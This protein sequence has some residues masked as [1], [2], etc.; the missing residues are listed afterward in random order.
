MP[1]SSP[2]LVGKSGSN[3]RVTGIRRENEQTAI[4]TTVGVFSARQ[5]INCAGLHSDAISRL[6]GAKL[7][8]QIVPF[9]GEYYE[10]APAKRHLVRGLI[11]PV[12]DPRFPF[13]GVHFTRRVNGAVEAGPNAVLALKREGYSKLSFS[14]EDA[15]GTSTFPGFWRMAARNW[16]HAV[17]EYYR[18]FS[19]TAFLHA[20]QKLLPDLTDADLHPGGCGVR[21]QAVAVDGKLVD[22][23]LFVHT[24]GIIHVCNVPS[25]AATASLVIGREI[26]NLLD[27]RS[28]RALAGQS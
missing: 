11:Y 8:F 25:P 5:V 14:I 12:P 15:F 4:E 7:D 24:E 23:F 10:L 27:Q 9:R 20:L 13:L 2:L 28:G 6:A 17:G 26:A 22:D 3:T 16:R 21:A 1:S 18:S 19:K